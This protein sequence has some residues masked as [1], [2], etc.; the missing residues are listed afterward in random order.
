MIIL[1]CVLRVHR[2]RVDGASPK[3][4]WFRLGTC[5]C[6]WLARAYRGGSLFLRGL[7]LPPLPPPLTG[8][9]SFIP[10]SLIGHRASSIPGAPPMVGSASATR[11]TPFSTNNY[12]LLLGERLGGLR[13]E[14]SRRE[15]SARA[16]VFVCCCCLCVVRVGCAWKTMAFNGK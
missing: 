1:L 5:L 15:G 10:R 2:A 14:G 4:R 12:R 6:L 8:A 3:N 7:A 11:A 13:A 9:R 16:R